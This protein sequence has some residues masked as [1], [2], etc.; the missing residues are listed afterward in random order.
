[1]IITPMEISNAYIW[2]TRLSGLTKRHIWFMGKFFDEHVGEDATFFNS[3]T[4]EMYK[5]PPF[6]DGEFDFVFLTGE[7]KHVFV[8]YRR[9]EAI[10]SQARLDAII[11]QINKIENVH[12]IWDEA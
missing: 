2:A 5:H 11:R 9:F 1:M 12:I 4:V 10:Q 8:A 6:L 3:G 7:A